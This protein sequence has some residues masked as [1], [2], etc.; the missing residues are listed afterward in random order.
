MRRQ[1][2]RD[3][4]RYE[5]YLNAFHNTV[6]QYAESLDFDNRKDY[7]KRAAYYGV[8]V[9]NLKEKS[10]HLIKEEAELNFQFVSVVKS[11]I[12]LLT[13]AEFMTLFPIEK[14]HKSHRWGMKDYFYT[15]DYI[16][17]LDLNKTIAEQEDPL[18]F[19]W[20]Y[21][22]WDITEFNVKA[23]CYLSDLRQLEGYPSSATEWAEMNGIQTFS[24]HRDS[25]GNEFIIK[26]GKTAKLGKQKPKYLK[27]VK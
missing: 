17:T 26:N 16:N 18:L 27:L 21:T 13:P 14:E 22:N 23:M 15:R 19:L 5:I 24:V 20:E 7:I 10:E 4:K 1:R 12:G 9:V 3:N 2:D 11:I 6:S 8:K 25:K